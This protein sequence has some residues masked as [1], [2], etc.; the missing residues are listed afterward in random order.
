MKNIL[1]STIIRNESKF[2]D[3]WHQQLKELAAFHKENFRFYLSVYENDSTDDSFQK[4]SSYDYSFLGNKKLVSE[5]L[6]TPYFIGGMNPIRTQILAFARN[7]SIYGYRF[8]PA[9]DFVL[10]IE[11]DIK[12]DVTKSDIILC[13]HEKVY[14]KSF[15]ILSGKS[16]HV[17]SP[18]RIYDTWGTRIKDDTDRW[19]DADSVFGGLEPLYSTFNCFALYNA[20]PI[21]DGFG[22]GGVNKR[23][24]K[25]DCDTSV[26]CENFRSAGHDK[27]FW[28]TDFNVEHF[29]E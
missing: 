8:L 19:N 4:L 14:G 23:T 29:C 2:L 6:N 5:K 11:P 10:V 21:K 1:I 13:D 16:I 26:I 15:D 22:F 3:R 24:G 27:I 17:G 7:E 20:K 9:I 28:H 25:P 12:Y 18:E